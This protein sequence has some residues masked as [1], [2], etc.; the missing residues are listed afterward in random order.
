LHV[1]FGYKIE[2]MGLALVAVHYSSDAAMQVVPF[3]FVALCKVVRAGEVVTCE[4]LPES[5]AIHLVMDR[6]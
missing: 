6:S 2:D 1:K 3:L 4:E 5:L